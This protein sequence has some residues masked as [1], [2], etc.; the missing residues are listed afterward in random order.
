MALNEEWNR[1][2][3]EWQKILWKVLY[4][5]LG[6]IN[7]SGFITKEYLSA[8][9][10]LQHKLSPMPTGTAWGAKWEYAWLK[11]EVQVPKEAAGKRI[12]L[13]LETGGIEALVWSNGEEIGSVGGWAHRELTLTPKAKAG[14]KIEILIE[15]YAGHGRTYWG[16]GPIPYGL[17]SIPEPPPTQA[18]MGKSTFG[19]WLEDVYQLALDFTTLR[20]LRDHL[21]PLSLRV[22]EIDEALMQATLVVDLEVPD[23]E[24]LQT[25]KAGRKLLKPLLEK[26]N[27]PTM[28]TLHAFGHAHLDVAWLWPWQE[29]ERKMARTIANTLAL[30]EEYPDY[31]FLQ[32]QSHLYYMLANRYPKLYERFEKAIK[33][34]TIIVDGAMWVESDTNLAGGEALIRQVMYGQ[35]FFRE[36]FG[37]ESK[38]LWL[39]DVFGYSGAVPQILKGCGCV[40]FA[41]Q[42]ITWAYNGGEKFPYNIF[43]W[44]GIDGSAI[45]AHIFTDYNSQTNPDKT[46]ERWNT[47]LQLNGIDSFM[48]SFGWGDGGGG[49]TRDH[50]EYLARSKDLEGLPRVKISTPAAFFQDLKKKGLPKE[51][52]VGEL[53]FQ[54]HRG[55]YTSQAKTK[56]GNRRSEFA[57]REAELWGS[58]ARVLKA[59]SFTPT[60]LED[61]WRRL[62]LNQFHDVLP[63]SSIQR[64]YQEA[65]VEFDKVIQ[66]AQESTLAALSTLIHKE[67]AV[68]VFNSLSWARKALVE[69]PGGVAEVTVPACGW[70]TVDLKSTPA[71]PAKTSKVKATKSSLEN[72][73]LRV[74]FNNRGEITSLLDKET[75]S[76]VMAGPG[77]RF[78]LYKD[79]PTAWD[80][81]DIDSMAEQSPV[82][83]NEPVKLEVLSSGPLTA[84]IRL[85]RK[86]KKSSISQIITLRSGSRRID[87]ATTVDWQ[88]SHRLLKVSFPVDIYTQEAIHEIQFGHLRRPNH[89]S[90]V[91]DQDRFEVCNHKWTALAEENRGVA[92]LN[93]SKYGVSVQGNSINLT[94]LKS[95]LAPDMYA[96]KGIQTF[97]YSLYPWNGSLA[98]SEVV[99]EGYE[100]N[101]PV[102]VMP[103]AA[104]ER[105]LF[106]LDAANI[107]IEAVKPAEDGSPDLIV[108]L[109]EAK[110]MSTRCALTTSLPAKAATQTDLVENFVSNLPC[111]DGKIEL[112]FRPF[113]IK[114]VRLAL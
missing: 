10:A 20:E 35:K 34:G 89:R 77:N 23:D 54:G 91:Y 63:G 4:R 107:I 14:E 48:Y 65:E 71:V 100:L 53:Y 69:V 94:L 60:S 85:K 104:G 19:I 112:S 36:K 37:V 90:R 33:D 55:T 70:T 21:D 51:R 58:A 102:L 92:V 17:E 13:K 15:S 31:K 79:V 109:Y 98:E 44:E 5:P 66:A 111:Q 26:K 61:P 9:E 22:A 103:G 86:M 64:V 42:K 12:N 50:L 97:T 84:Q 3:N 114:T 8:E 75:G 105:S 99:R 46:F 67:V 1:R 57:L 32:S 72:E 52:Y 27:G 7:F 110:R 113:E 96:D 28:P 108:R 47:R 78:N 74:E 95:A 59:F 11:G 87:F 73:L 6:E 68:T 49:P 24:M 39:P 18:V 106:N 56:K 16:E 25:V 45:P 88:E 81:W 38:V 40:G 83:I 76:E 80:A 41:T 30:A 62:M 101:V 82:E 29:T 2:V 93:D 43:W